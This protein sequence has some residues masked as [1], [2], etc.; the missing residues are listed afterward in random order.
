MFWDVLK[1]SLFRVLLTAHF[2]QL[3]QRIFCKQFY[4]T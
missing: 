4:R 2:D 1:C 3:L